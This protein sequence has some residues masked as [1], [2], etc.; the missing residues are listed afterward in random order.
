MQT[1]TD[2]ALIK[3]I[4]DHPEQGIKIALQ[5]Y[6]GAVKTI[7]SNIMGRDRK[8]DVE[9]CIS[10][11]FFQLWKDCSRYNPDYPLK[12]YIYGIARYTALTMRKKL[13]KTEQLITVDDIGAETFSG[14]DVAK[15]VAERENADM[16]YRE[17][18]AFPFPDKE[19]FLY[20][21]YFWFSIQEIADM[22]GLSYKAVENRLYR[23]KEKL[24][25]KLTERGIAL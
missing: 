1:M 2:T 9:E 23:G 5:L 3:E 16:V 4:K 10:E 6:G 20:R 18:L 19:I 14:A 8:N 12:N 13:L 21:Y 11:V 24:R 17:M 15:F 7:C 25:Q 22:L